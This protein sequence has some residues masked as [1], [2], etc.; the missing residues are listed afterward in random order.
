MTE[1][2]IMGVEELHRY[3][4]E[5]P[6]HI[7][8]NIDKGEEEWLKIVQKSAKL[9]APRFTGQLAESISYKQSGVGKWELIVAS[10]YGWFQE[11][12][13]SPKWVPAIFSSR[14]GYTVGD[15]MDAKDIAGDGIFPR[16]IPHPFISPAFEYGRSIIA[17]ILRRAT[18]D[19]MKK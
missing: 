8:D 2:T 7:T 5:L 10:P 11:V 13:W 16:G 3:L 12:G 6:S 18:D 17:D 15:W 1:I 19:G 9:R 4:E 14:A